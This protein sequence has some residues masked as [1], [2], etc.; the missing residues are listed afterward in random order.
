MN[1]NDSFRVTFDTESG[2]FEVF[3]EDKCI[4]N[5]LTLGLFYNDDWIGETTGHIIYSG[6][7]LASKSN[8]ENNN[9]FEGDYTEITKEFSITSEQDVFQVQIMVYVFPAKSTLYVNAK[10]I[11]A[12]A[13]FNT[14]C[15]FIDLGVPQNVDAFR[16]FHGSVRIF[17]PINLLKHQ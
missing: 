17:L 8:F 10:V 3:Y 12:P 13:K 4:L 6:G 11:D 16:Y 15:G 9:F 7:S 1:N 14:L 2:T 5:T